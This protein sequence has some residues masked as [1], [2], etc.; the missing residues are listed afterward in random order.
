MRRVVLDDDLVSIAGRHVECGR[1][2][3][4]DG[5]EKQARIAG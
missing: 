3:I 2:D 4:V 5:V 1:G